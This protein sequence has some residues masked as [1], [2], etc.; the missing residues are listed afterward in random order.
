MTFNFHGHKVV[1]K[2]LFPKGVHEDQIKMKTKRENEKE[3]ERK[4]TPSH[5]ISSYTTKSIMLTRAMLPTAPPRC[6]S[7]LSFSLP[8]NSKYLT[9]FDILDKDV[10]G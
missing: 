6:T 3:K 5:H 4:D 9:S 8:N 10:L 1:L 7:S 2:P